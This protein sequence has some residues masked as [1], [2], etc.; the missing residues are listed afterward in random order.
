MKMID[1]STI[2]VVYMLPLCRNYIAVW[3]GAIGLSITRALLEPDFEIKRDI[4]S[5]PLQLNNRFIVGMTFVSCSNDDDDEPV[6]NN[7][8]KV[9]VGTWAQDGDND[10]LTINANGYWSVVQQSNRLQK[11][12]SS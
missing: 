6:G 2:S 10:I 12:S 3:C 7:L 1:S 9:V 4:Y 11:Q 5:T 8:E